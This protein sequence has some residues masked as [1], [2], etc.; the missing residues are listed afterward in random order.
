M[1][2]DYDMELFDMD[3]D[4]ND[5]SVPQMRQEMNA[6]GEGAQSGY[7]PPMG[8]RKEAPKYEQ[9][10][11]R[12]PSS[13]TYDYLNPPEGSFRPSSQR[14]VAIT[15]PKGGVGKSSTTKELGYAFASEVYDSENGTPLKVLLVD[16]DWGHPSLTSILNVGGGQHKISAWIKTMIRNINSTGHPGVFRAR[17]IDDFIVKIKPNLHLL[18]L[19]RDTMDSNML[20][21]EMVRAITQSI[22]CTDYDLVIYDNRNEIEGDDRSLAVCDAVDMIFMLVTSDTTTLQN[23]NNTLASLE[24][25]QYDIK[26]IHF[27]QN[28]VDPKAKNILPRDIENHYGVQLVT[29]I[30]K[31]D[32]MTEINNESKALVNERPNSNYSKAIFELA[33]FIL[34]APV[35]KKKGLFAGLFGKR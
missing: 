33:E 8:G 5:E 13:P 25:L 1:S 20:T 3:D 32:E 23:I 29:E 11:R 6:S 9:S 10:E 18:T 35:K 2:S 19:T 28:A 31:C 16:A 14:S 34:P 7:V 27:V 4:L 30:P 22:S 17:Y 12:R 24:S 26:R 15:C 21:P